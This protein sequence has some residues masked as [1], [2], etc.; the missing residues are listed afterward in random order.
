MK[1]SSTQPSH[2]GGARGGI[3]PAKLLIPRW[4]SSARQFLDSSCQCPP[5][6]VFRVGVAARKVRAGQAKDSHHLWP[7]N[8]VAQQL[9]GDPKVGDTP[10]GMGKPLQNAQAMQPGLID[11][12]SVAWRPGLLDT[13]GETDAGIGAR[14]G[15]LRSV[16]RSPGRRQRVRR[17]LYQGAPLRGQHPF[18][19]PDFHPGSQACHQT[20]L[21]FLIGKA[22]QSSQMTTIGAGSIR[23]IELGQV[24]GDGGSDGDGQRLGTDSDPS[25]EVARAGFGY[26]A[27]L[28][29]VGPHQLQD[30]WLN[31]IQVHEN[32]SRIEATDEGLE[33]DVI[34]I[35]VASAQKLNAALVSQLRGRPQSFAG[36]RLPVDAVDQTNQI[37]IARQGCELTAD[38]LHRQFQSAVPAERARRQG[39]WMAD[40]SPAPEARPMTNWRRPFRARGI[41]IAYGGFYGRRAWLG[42]GGWRFAQ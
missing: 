40:S 29:A 35:T 5:Q 13:S 24:S 27:R 3:P 25:L 30:C 16:K 26:Q 21:G 17:D 39:D 37:V 11:R 14:A 33:I 20:P 6:V 31:A 15:C 10:V 18:G 36:E 9:F 4:K 42:G 34:S 38:G 23:L 28:V 22:G 8:L 7:W 1:L 32:V 2:T 19:M 41:S 12:G